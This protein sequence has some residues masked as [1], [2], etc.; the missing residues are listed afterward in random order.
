MKPEEMDALLRPWVQ[1]VSF[2]PRTEPAPPKPVEADPGEWDDDETGSA[3]DA[4]PA[5]P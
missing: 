5:A 2:A 1:T 3:Q 4:T